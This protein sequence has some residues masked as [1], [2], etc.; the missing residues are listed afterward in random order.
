M[1]HECRRIAV[2]LI[3]LLTAPAG[4]FTQSASLVEQETDST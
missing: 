4:V 1:I 3:A 2:M